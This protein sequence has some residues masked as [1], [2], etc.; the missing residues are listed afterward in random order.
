MIDCDE[1]HLCLRGDADVLSAVELLPL[2]DDVAGA[3]LVLIVRRFDEQHAVEDQKEAA[4]GLAWLDE[5]VPFGQLELA[6]NVEELR[7]EVLVDG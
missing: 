2:A 6:P 1:S 5:H 3:A 4:D 7:D